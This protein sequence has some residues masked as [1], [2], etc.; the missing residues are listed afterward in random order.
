MSYT[1][2]DKEF[3]FRDDVVQVAKDLL[4]MYLISQFDGQRTVGRILET[5]AYRGPEDKACHA[6]NNRYTKR[7]SIMFAEAGVAYVTLCYGIHHLFNVVTGFEGQPHAV[8][9]RALAPVEG[10]ET[11]LKRRNMTKVAPR[12]MAGPGSLSKAMG[13][14]TAYHGQSIIS[15][16]SDIYLGYGLSA[17]EEQIIASP[18]VGINYAEEWVDMPWRFRIKAP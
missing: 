11:M 17:T 14:T 16:K 10:I 18:R 12:L 6:Y 13:I 1:L 15:T 7:T 5:E 8:L 2:I 4:G 3:Y 9:I